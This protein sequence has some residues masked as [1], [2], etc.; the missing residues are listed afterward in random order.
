MKKY[1]TGIFAVMLALCASAFTTQSAKK[2]KPTK[3]ITGSAYFYLTTDNVGDENTAALWDIIPSQD[4]GDV[5]CE[6][7]DVL[8]TIYAPIA[9]PTD[10]HPD[11][12]GISD[13]RSSELVK[14][15]VFKP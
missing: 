1:L 14:E 7:E 12:T 6:G 2:A 4:P 15:K 11:F 5:G 8:C 10:T 13:V 3:T 9:N